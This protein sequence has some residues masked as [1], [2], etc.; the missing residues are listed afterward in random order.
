MK[1]KARIIIKQL[2]TSYKY[3]GEK[4][5][6]KMVLAYSPKLYKKV[7]QDVQ[8]LGFKFCASLWLVAAPNR[9]QCLHPDCNNRTKPD[10]QWGKFKRYCS[11]RCGNS[12]PAKLERMVNTC[13]SKYGTSNV[14]KVAAVK[15]SKVLTCRKNFGV[16]A[17]QQS[18]IV[19]AT[20][21][22]NNLR[23]YNYTNVG[24]VEEFKLKRKQT[25]IK[26]F[27]VDNPWRST[28]VK[29]KI[30]QHFQEKYGV[31]HPSQV[32]EIM[33][34]SM[35]SRS[36]PLNLTSKPRIVEVG[37]K[38]FVCVGY[39]GLAIKYIHES[40]GVPVKHITNRKVKTFPYFDKKK[41]KMRRYYPDVKIN[42][43]GKVTYV[44]V[45]GLMTLLGYETY[46][47]LPNVKDK[48]QAVNAAGYSIILIAFESKN[49][50]KPILMSTTAHNASRKKI[51]DLLLTRTN[52]KQVTRHS[53][54]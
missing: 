13:T 29:A 35:S 22:S 2:N 28:E 30:K 36:N 4:T 15:V 50:E 49:S 7:E 11:I 52:S 39:E 23:K 38:E 16:D 48:L 54:A 1:Q 20:L 47:P 34:R 9:N 41:K 12:D 3:K 25:F 14:S 27:G 37:G 43:H 6:K 5:V 8:R 31:D 42:L 26:R 53:V 18:A 46:N 51:V 19:R 44:E 33:D 21:E 40:L 32:A 24:Q 17:P 45:K 10:R